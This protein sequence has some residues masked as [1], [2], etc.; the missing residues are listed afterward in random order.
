MEHRIRHHRERR[1]PDWVTIDAPVDLAGALTQA[2]GA[3]KATVVDCL[4][5]WLTNR[6]LDGDDPEGAIVE[7]AERVSDLPG[8]TVFVSNEV[9]GGIVPD[10]RLARSFRDAQGRLNQEMAA[11]CDRAVLVVAGLPMML[12]GELPI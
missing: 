1:G 9:G 10:N 8:L 11:A 3:D 2:S 4:T 5:L 7:L 12:K 6:M